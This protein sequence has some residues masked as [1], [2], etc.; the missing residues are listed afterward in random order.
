MNSAIAKTSLKA[1]FVAL[2]IIGL[3][4]MSCSKSIEPK[5][6]KTVAPPVA[7]KVAIQS[8]TA[9]MNQ[10]RESEVPIPPN[11][12]LNVTANQ[13]TAWEF[14][15]N[16][17]PNVAVP[18]QRAEIYAYSDPVKRGACLALLRYGH[19]HPQQ[20]FICQSATT[21]TSCFWNKDEEPPH[22]GHP[23]VHP[24]VAIN[25]LNDPIGS[26]IGG[27]KIKLFEDC[28]RCHRGNNAFIL[29]PDDQ[30]WAKVLRGPLV[31]KAGSTFTTKVELSDSM[32]NNGRFRHIPMGP[33]GPNATTNPKGTS[34][35]SGEC[36]ER[37]DYDQEF[38][39][40]L[41]TPSH[42]EFP[43]PPFYPPMPPL[44]SRNGN[45]CSR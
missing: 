29:F 34:E 12:V 16:L 35:C 21:G 39:R 28:I 6:G 33:D 27:G 11:L 14:L 31:T 10:C 13:P 15:G 17:D 9:Y 2:M 37:T 41:A 30:L 26:G 42:I 45:T 44:C 24:E 40:I 23:G 43:A 7:T 18:H 36:H 20:G 32:D 4:L 3:L 25:T 22:G 8:Y 38:R 19:E 1:R 5:D